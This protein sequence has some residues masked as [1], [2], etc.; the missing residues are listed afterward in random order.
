[1]KNQNVV[2]RKKQS[3]EGRGGEGGAAAGKKIKGGQERKN[4]KRKGGL[5]METLLAHQSGAR[6]NQVSAVQKNS[7]K[8]KGKRRSRGR[9]QVGR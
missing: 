1:M 8:K 2:P 6:H 9:V 7:R 4:G 3:G 5:R